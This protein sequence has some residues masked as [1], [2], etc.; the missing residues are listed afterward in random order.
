MGEMPVRSKPRKDLAASFHSL[1]RMVGDMK[2]A[3]KSL[4]S[5]R[6]LVAELVSVSLFPR[7]P[8][9]K[10]SSPR[11][12]SHLMQLD[13]LQELRI[14]SPSP[15]RNQ[16]PRSASPSRRP[17]KPPLLNRPFNQQLVDL[18]DAAGIGSALLQL[19]D[20]QEVGFESPRAE[21]PVTCSVSSPKKLANPTLSSLRSLA[22][23]ISAL[24]APSPPPSVRSS[25]P[26]ALSCCKILQEPA[27]DSINSGN[28]RAQATFWASLLSVF[29]CF[30]LSI[31]KEFAVGVT[32]TAYF[33]FWLTFKGRF[34]ANQPIGSAS[35]SL[36]HQEDRRGRPLNRSST[37]PSNY[38]GIF[39]SSSESQLSTRSQSLPNFQ[40]CVQ[41]EPYSSEPGFSVYS[42]AS[43]ASLS[44]AGTHCAR[45]KLGMMLALALFGLVH[46]QVMAVCVCSCC[47]LILSEVQ[48]LAL[49]IHK[50]RSS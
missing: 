12:P 29:L 43:T 33:V 15:L 9:S 50:Q 18:H 19:D 32:L 36:H 10:G 22:S 21:S 20:L 1:R 47:V 27:H 44:N 34:V 25:H 39:W 31:G 30:F 8:S 7:V 5:H 23:K 3:R 6:S 45:L 11:I 26:S 35:P 41:E 49:R 46:G 28:L 40:G 17:A 2:S 14:P 48:R 16:T 38:N 24:S 37:F 4:A 42:V 13:D